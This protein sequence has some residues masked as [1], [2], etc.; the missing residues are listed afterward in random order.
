MAV[1]KKNLRQSRLLEDA[2]DDD[3]RVG[4][5]NLAD[6]ML[7]FACGLMVALIAH[8]NV[9][10]APSDVQESEVGDVE[11]LEDEL[12]SARQG[13]ESNDASYAQV[14]TVYRD[15]ETGELYVVSPNDAVSE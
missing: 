10:I 3:P 9:N 7:V 5:V 6:V 4:L 11:K 14:G 1:G 2:A 13:I 8:Y 15:V 12:I